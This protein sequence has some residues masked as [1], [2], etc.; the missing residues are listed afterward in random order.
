MSDNETETDLVL[1]VQ[2]GDLTAF[3]EL[4]NLHSSHLRAFVALKLPIPHLIDEIAH[5]TFVFAHRQILDFKAGTDFGKWL[6]AIAFNLVRRET[7]RHQRLSTN[8][9]K[10][11]EHSLI[12]QAGSGT[13]T[14]DSPVIVYLEECLLKLPEEQ[15]ALLEHK[16]KLSESSREIA[17]AFD[18]S[19]TWVRTTLCRIRTALR[20]CIEAKLETSPKPV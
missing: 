10:F 6:R 3:E 12:Q 18:Q 15:R 2:N 4:L 1:R 13:T 14:P 17:R 7:L 9:E 19:E 5:E 16:Y 8:R 11:L 20:R